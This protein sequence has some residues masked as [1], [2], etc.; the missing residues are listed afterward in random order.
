MSIQNIMNTCFAICITLLIYQNTQLKDKLDTSDVFAQ[1]GVDMA[2]DRMDRMESRISDNK[3][4]LLMQKLTTD[5]IR[6]LLGEISDS[7]YENDVIL[8]KRIDKISEW[9]TANQDYLF[10]K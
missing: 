3:D 6:D 5:E 2:W 10:N 8:Q 7:R 9:I 4:S 1:H